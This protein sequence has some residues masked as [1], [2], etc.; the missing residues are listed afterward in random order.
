M[1]VTL[2]S[3]DRSVGASLDEWLG[4]RGHVLCRTLRVADAEA[5]MRVGETDLVIVDLGA[6]GP[7]DAGIVARLRAADA[8]TPLLVLASGAGIDEVVALLDKGA[9]RCLTRRSCTEELTAYLRMCCRRFLGSSTR[10]VQRGPLRYDSESRTAW[11]GEAPLPLTP[12]EVLLLE[13][14][15]RTRGRFA[16]KRGLVDFLNLHGYAVTNNGLEAH[17]HRMRGKLARGDLTI[18]AVRGLGYRLAWP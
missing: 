4:A 9:D 8:S 14:L 17:I 3:A 10:F 7:V 6:E 11:C 1:R 2:L 16:A 13:A 18:R 5:S 15:I 12:S